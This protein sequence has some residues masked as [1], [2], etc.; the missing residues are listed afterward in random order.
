MVHFSH[1]D[2]YQCVYFLCKE[3]NCNAIKDLFAWEGA[4]KV[5]LFCQGSEMAKFGSALLW[6]P[7]SH[8]QTALSAGICHA[9]SLVSVFG[10][11]LQD[12]SM[13][14]EMLGTA[15]PL[16]WV[17]LLW[18]RYLD[19]WICARKSNTWPWMWRTWIVWRRVCIF[20][21]CSVLVWAGP[22][23]MCSWYSSCAE[24]ACMLVYN[25]A[26]CSTD[27]A[28]VDCALLRYS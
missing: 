16:T 4:D 17:K 15:L 27:S 24:C 18:D 22:C 5:N 28:I 8:I 21:L 2:V 12:R 20:G 6:K 14:R 13:D 19:G 3:E 25:T 9:F 26:F 10:T 11:S 1:L 7:F 23:V